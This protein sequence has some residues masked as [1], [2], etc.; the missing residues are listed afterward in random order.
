MG[1]RGARGGREG[2][3]HPARQTARQHGPPAPRVLWPARPRP[4]SA[5]RTSERASERASQPA[6]PP[7]TPSDIHTSN[8][9]PAFAPPRPATS[10]PLPEYTLCC[11]C[12]CP[13]VRRASKGAARQPQ[14]RRRQPMGL[15]PLALRLPTCPAW[16]THPTP[17]L[18]L[19]APPCLRASSPLHLLVVRRQAPQTLLTTCCC[20]EHWHRHTPSRTVRCSAVQCNTYARMHTHTQ[21]GG[22]RT[23]RRALAPT[24]LIPILTT[25]TSIPKWFPLLFANDPGL[26]YV[27]ARARWTAIQD[28]ETAAVR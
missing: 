28:E 8:A 18:W 25:A 19:A 7:R 15:C 1:E 22:R 3:N 17:R 26:L 11:V 9:S 14:G 23:R 16:V 13:Y 24:P 2:G 4:H 27:G 6:A 20:C 5:P 10:T 21:V 12:A